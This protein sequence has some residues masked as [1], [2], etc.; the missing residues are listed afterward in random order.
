MKIQ[1][2]TVITLFVMVIISGCTSPLDSLAG[3]KF[4]SKN[5]DKIIR[6]FA[7]VE[8][9][10]SPKQVVAI[11]GKPAVVKTDKPAPKMTVPL[12]IDD[13]TNRQI[14]YYPGCG[15]IT[16]K[17]DIHTRRYKVVT[18]V[19]SGSIKPKKPAMTNQ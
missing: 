18:I 2:L 7:K 13:A 10:M 8:P 16:F 14:W 19:K 15:L 5:Q 3:K 12:R 9:G 4:D 11:L 1:H 17:V 6:G